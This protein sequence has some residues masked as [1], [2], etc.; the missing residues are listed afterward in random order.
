ML[1]S[2]DHEIL[3]EQKKFKFIEH[4]RIAFEEMS[5]PPCTGRINKVLFKYY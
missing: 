1:N 3:D 2:H 5:T 4:D